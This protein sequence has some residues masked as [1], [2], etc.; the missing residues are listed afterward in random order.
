MASQIDME[1]ARRIG[2]T[3]GARWR[4]LTFL[5]RRLWRHRRRAATRDISL[6]HSQ[7]SGSLFRGQALLKETSWCFVYDV[8]PRADWEELRRHWPPAFEFDPPKPFEAHK[9][10]D[11]GFRGSREVRPPRIERYQK[12][13]SVYDWLM[14]P[15][16]GAEIAALCGDGIARHCY[17]T[18]SNTSWWG[19]ALIPH[20]DTFSEEQEQIAPL[21]VNVIY[22]VDA[23]GTGW[24][25]G[26]TAIL[27]DASFDRPKFIP[28]VLRNTALIYRSHNTF[29]GFPPMG[30]RAF[31]HV[32]TAHFKPSEQR[33]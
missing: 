13:A 23:S 31:R 32:I 18:V 14:L 11:T 33:T 26:G 3:P 8:L 9:I 5:P 17:H 16:T 19:S 24:E 10:Y 15:E 27:E 28:P 30:R 2:S 21:Y 20:T 6:G 22:F 29:H 7:T 12:F 4:T 1:L 25:A